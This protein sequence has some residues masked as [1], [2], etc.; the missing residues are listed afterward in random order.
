MIEIGRRTPAQD[1]ALGAALLAL[2]AVWAAR[3]HMGDWAPDLSAIYFAARFYGLGLMDQ[4][5][6]SPARFFG[7]DDAPRWVAEVAALGHGDA[8]V[9]PYIY[10]PLWAALFAPVAVRTDPVDFFAAAWAVQ[11]AMMA[12]S[13]WLAWRLMRPGT[14]FAAWSALSVLLLATS[15]ISFH[16]LFHSQPQITVAFLCLLAFE[17]LA[18]GRPL[19]AGAALG[20]AAALKLTPIL[21]A[22]IFLAERQYRAALTALAVAAGLALVSLIVAGPELHWVFIEKLR[23]VSQQLIVWDFNYSLRAV[24]W[25]VGQIATGT[26]MPPPEPAEPLVVFAPAWVGLVAWAVLLAGGA[27]LI[28]TTRHLP[29]PERL[30]RRTLAGFLLITL[31]SP[32]SWTHQYLFALFLLP[33]LFGILPALPAALILAGFAALFSTPVAPHVSTLSEALNL[34]VW[35][36]VAAMSLLALTVALAPRRDLPRRLQSST[37]RR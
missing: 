24:F 37:D 9:Y 21:L 32:L 31:C 19:A 7:T 3:I 6:A 26:P 28:R 13:V 18:A 8:Q 10:P 14:S 25:Q 20:L 23:V 34:E 12:A 29:P 17:R 22:L 35:T 30:R 36:G 15:I 4:V 16:A 27:V 1:R 11:I 2:W 5:Y 33:G